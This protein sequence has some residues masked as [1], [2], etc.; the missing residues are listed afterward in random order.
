MN[1]I[2]IKK[3]IEKNSIIF[4]MF[5]FQLNNFIDFSRYYTFE[6]YNITFFHRNRSTNLRKNFFRFSV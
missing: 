1:H 5:F 6:N 2:H 4:S 3:E